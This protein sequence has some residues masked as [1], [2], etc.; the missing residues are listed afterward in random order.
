MA[1]QDFKRI[2]HYIDGIMP[3]KE[4]FNTVIITILF[5]IIFS[6]QASNQQV[7]NIIIIMEFNI[8]KPHF[9]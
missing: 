4:N 5:C 8:I 9:S 1:I 6:Y 3:F 7:F 2:Q